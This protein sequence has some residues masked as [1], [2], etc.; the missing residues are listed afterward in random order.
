[1]TWAASIR[2]RYEKFWGTAE[3]IS[4]FDKGPVPDLPDD[5]A[6]VARRMVEA[7]TGYELFASAPS[8]NGKWLGALLRSAGIPRHALRL[9][10]RP[11]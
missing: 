11:A 7:L 6:V 4:S 2:A 9:R 3:R 5:F 8:C 1:M 10:K